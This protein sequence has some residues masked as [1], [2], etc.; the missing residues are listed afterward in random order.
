MLQRSIFGKL[1]MNKAYTQL[2]GTSIF[3]VVTGFA[4]QHLQ[5]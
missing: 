5:G 4:G 3:D 1:K 2:L